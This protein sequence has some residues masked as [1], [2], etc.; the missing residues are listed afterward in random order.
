M[1][2]TQTPYGF[3]PVGT[4]TGPYNGQLRKYKIASGYATSIYTGD[5]VKSQPTSSTGTI[6]LEN[7]TSTA[8]P[9]GVFMGCEYTNPSTGQKI[10]SPY[11][12]ASTVASD[13]VAFVFDNPLGVFQ[14]QA[15]GPITQTAC[16]Q[17]IAIGT[18]VAGS[19]NF[20]ISRV[21][22]GTAGAASNT[23]PFRII[24][25]V[26]GP[27]SVIGDAYTDLLVTYNFGMHIYMDPDGSAT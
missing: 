13:A 16:F 1:A 19:A 24:G 4:L 17:N 5:L 2:S 15:G 12:P 21:R 18:Y 9:V 20:G 14:V 6:V 11:W 10:Q 26:D 8:A 23:L 3:R 27:D 25:F 22:V 7:G